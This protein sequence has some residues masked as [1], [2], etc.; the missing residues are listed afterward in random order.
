MPPELDPDPEG[1]AR[2][3]AERIG[4][5]KIRKQQELEQ[6]AKDA[7]E[8]K[9]A[10]S[11][12]H[13]AREEARKKQEAIAV[14]RAAKKKEENDFKEAKFNALKEKRLKREQ[15]LRDNRD[16]RFYLQAKRKCETALLKRLQ[17]EGNAR[18]RRLAK[19]SAQFP[20][21]KDALNTNYRESAVDNYD[22]K[23]DLA[24]LESRDNGSSGPIAGGRPPTAA[25]S[26]AALA[27]APSNP[28]VNV[29]GT[30]PRQM[31]KLPELYDIM[32]ERGML[33]N[34]MKE[35]K[36]VVLQRLD[37]EDARMSVSD[38]RT[39]LRKRG[40]LTNGTKKEMV[41]RMQ[42]DD[43]KRSSNYKRRYGPRPLKVQKAA[44]GSIE[45]EAPAT[46]GPNPSRFSAKSNAR[47]SRYNA[48][49]VNPGKS[50]PLTKAITKPTISNPVG[51]S[52]RVAMRNSKADS[53][54]A[55]AGKDNAGT[56]STST[57]TAKKTAPAENTSAKR[58]STRNSLNENVGDTDDSEPAPT[59]SRDET[60][61]EDEDE[62][63]VEEEEEDGDDDDYEDP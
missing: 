59:Q 61:G 42:E 14:A 36:G 18:S 8:E 39:E 46:P 34:R 26:L 24:A 3:R 11:K 51:S 6:Q 58:R 25:S 44:R 55:N 53:T 13:K 5:F 57:K 7:E 33:L 31:L 21:P 2:E 41:R 12:K 48:R 19:Y 15:N 4:A 30:E 32:R 52:I 62:Q 60:K 20:L 29:F 27:N 10:K 56:K 37:N 9:R 38:L 50:K 43:A 23:S 49:E 16:E 45:Q 17:K 47:H 40:L 35:V 54:S 63:S 28:N 22:Y 1:R